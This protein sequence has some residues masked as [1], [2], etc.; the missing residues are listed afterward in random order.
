MR[1]EEQSVGQAP[2]RKH[3]TVMID[4]VPLPERPEERMQ[5]V[6]EG[7]MP[8]ITEI[9]IDAMTVAIGTWPTPEIPRS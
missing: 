5:V 9:V 4:T 7:I 3:Y 8:A 1:P 2:F 6:M